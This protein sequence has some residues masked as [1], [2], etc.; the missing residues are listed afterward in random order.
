MFAQLQTNK[1]KIT[2]MLY[3]IRS[4]KAHFIYRNIFIYPV[5]CEHYKW[6]ERVNVHNIY[7]ITFSIVYQSI[8]S[9]I[10]YLLLL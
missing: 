9:I 1:L 2:Y 10:Y 8:E 5:Q 6:K 7:I 3:D 4:C